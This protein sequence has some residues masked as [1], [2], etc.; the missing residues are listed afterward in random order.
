MYLHCDPTASHYLKV[1]CDSV[2]GAAGFGNEIA[3]CYKGGGK[4]ETAFGRKHDAIL[5]Y[6][7]QPA[8]YVFNADSVR[9]PYEGEGRGRMDASRWGYPTQKPRAL[10]ERIIAASSNPGDVVLD[11]FCGCGTTVD[12]ARR[13]KR[14]F[15]G[16]D[17]SAF[18][19]DLVRDRRLRDPS[20][21]VHGIPS[22]VESAR[23]MAGDEP[24]QFETWAVAK[25]GFA[26]NSVQVGDGGID[27]RA[28]LAS[29]P[30]DHD[31]R[32]CVA[33]VAGGRFQ[34]GKWRDF[35]HV[36]EREN[37]AVGVFV[38]V[39]PV[40]AAVRA[41]AAGAGKL[42]V[43]GRSYPRLQAWSMVDHFG[44][45]AA[46]LPVLVDPYTGRAKEQLSLL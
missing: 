26:C 13:L 29:A 10:L 3:W 15:L 14:R 11:P 42:T 41:D 16:I 5:R 9:V 44:G 38:T 27:G 40:P 23:R 34:R 31:S 18:A 17:V 46:D 37:A 12:A 4:S 35:R 36:L 33:Q 1:L 25:L 45:H 20:V 22:D 8:G 21:P 28:V 6:T 32:A 30:D 7:V 24:F 19:V 2:F 39:D 43:N